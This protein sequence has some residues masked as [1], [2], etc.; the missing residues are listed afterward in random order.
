MGE[1]QS[2]MRLED[3]FGIRW[4]SFSNAERVFTVAQG[5]ALRV[6]RGSGL[7]HPRFPAG[8]FA[9]A[10]HGGGGLHERSIYWVPSVH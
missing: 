4:I 1:M 10:R 5:P 2:M 7:A 8:S 3:F 9:H 6:A